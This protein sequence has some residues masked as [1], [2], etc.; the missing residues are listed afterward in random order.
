MDLGNAVA[1]LKFLPTLHPA[2]LLP[3]RDPSLWGVVLHDLRRAKCEAEF[4][5]IRS[6]LATIQ[7]PGLSFYEV[8]GL[9][10]DIP[11]KQPL[12]VDVE[13][14]NNQ[15]SVIALAWSESRVLSI[16]F[17]ASNGERMW[18]PKE[19]EDLGTGIGYLLDK[20]D[21]WIGHNVA[22]FDAPR[23]RPFLNIRLDPFKGFCNMLAHHL[24]D[25]ELG[26][27][28]AT[29]QWFPLYFT[30]SVHTEL[31]YHKHLGDFTQ[32]PG[33]I[34]IHYCG[35]DALSSF[36]SFLGLEAD[37]RDAEML[38]YF[39]NEVMPLTSVVSAMEQRGILIDEDARL[40]LESH[41]KHQIEKGAV[42]LQEIAGDDFNPNSTKQVA[43]ILFEEFKL[44]II[45]TTKTGKPSTD[46]EV[47]GKLKKRASGIA[48]EFLEAMDAPR[49]SG[50]MLSTYI[51]KRPK[52]AWKGGIGV[53]DDGRHR[54]D[55]IMH[56][57]VSLRFATSPNLQNVPEI[58]RRM[59]VAPSGFKLINVDY[60]Q[61]ELRIMAYL[62]G[63]KKLIKALEAGD[64]I[65][66]RIASR[67]FGVPPEEVTKEQR[68]FGKV[69]AHQMDYGAT[70]HGMS[71]S[72]GITVREAERIHREWFEWVP[73]MGEYLKELAEQGNRDRKGVN[74]FGVVRKFLGHYKPNDLFNWMGQSTAACV[75]RRAMLRL[76]EHLHLLVQVHDS[77]LF[78]HPSQTVDEATQLIEE[79]MVYPVEI[80]GYNVTFPVT[81]KTGET[82]EEVS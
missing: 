14:W 13:L 47:L 25:A 4:P 32:P 18:S 34:L 62:S 64:D 72:L 24:L 37:L 69:C 49:T 54:F 58:I 30:Q 50:K 82:W 77:L 15:I 76:P 23:L 80:N 7:G 33:D 51:R 73:E 21:P 59:Y 45:K 53:G 10:R 28:K 48:L 5:E 19:E 42:I 70:P 9:I 29:Y 38:N 79:A 11:E 1:V 35:M 56:G 2:S 41:Y 57:T 12:A 16:P 20:A 75:I 17:V 36:Q 81:I 26:K 78:E 3:N 8:S 44:P 27:S 67:I 31:P 43:K 6:P 63:S 66:K 71:R 39:R 52:G 55:T 22:L 46:K 40:G 68:F 74:P 60:N 65:H 61:I